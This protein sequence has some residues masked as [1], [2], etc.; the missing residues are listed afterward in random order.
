M[1]NILSNVA[2]GVGWLYISFQLYLGFTTG[3]LNGIG[4]SARLVSKQDEPLWFY[5]VMAATIMFNLVILV[6]FLYSMFSAVD[7]KVKAYGGNYNINTFKAIF[8]GL[9]K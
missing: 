1:K 6:L 2:L 7:R 8:R 9:R 5:F 3:V 4:R